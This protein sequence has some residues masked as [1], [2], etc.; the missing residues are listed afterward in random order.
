MSYPQLNY[1]QDDGY[2]TFTIPD[3][4]LLRKIRYHREEAIDLRKQ[5][6]GTLLGYT[7][8]DLTSILN[9]YDC[10]MFPIHNRNEVRVKIYL[11]NDILPPPPK[12][13][14][15]LIPKRRPPPTPTPAK[16]RLHSHDLPIRPRIVIHEPDGEGRVIARPLS[17]CEPS[18][19]REIHPG[20]GHQHSSSGT[21]RA[22]WSNKIWKLRCGNISLPT[23]V[24]E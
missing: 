2:V 4:R 20:K 7:V 5:A 1:V 9:N 24:E 18:I 8:K 14:F 6:L 10:Q 17:H 11:S 13:P 16:S 15:P 21:L 22:R 19:E 3:A 23:I 12:K